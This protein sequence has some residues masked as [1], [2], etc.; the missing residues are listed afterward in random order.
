MKWKAIP[1]R[2]T[3]DRKGAGTSSGESGV[4]NLEAESIRSRAEST[5]G[6]VK[7]ETFT[8]IRRMLQ[9]VC[10]YGTFCH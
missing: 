2:G 6:C 1:C 9:H 3:E 7:L 4:G 10:H 5:G 8:E